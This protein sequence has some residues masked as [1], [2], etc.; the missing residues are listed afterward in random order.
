MDRLQTAIAEAR[1]ARDAILAGR[2]AAATDQEA[3]I[4]RKVAPA[5]SRTVEEAWAAL[6]RFEPEAEHLADKRVV[7]RQGGARS[8]PFDVLRTRTLQ[9]MKAQGWSRLAV[10]SPGPGCGKSTVTMNLA[11]SLARQTDIR[12]VVLDLDLRRPMLA[13]ILGLQARHEIT[14]AIRGT[15]EPGAQM[16]R[17][18]ENLAFATTRTPVHDPAE[19]LQGRRIGK[20]LERI[21][22]QF[23]PDVIVFDLPPVMVSDDA[24]A[25]L[26]NAD[27]ALMIA[28]AEQSTLGQVDACEKELAQQTN[29]LGVVLNKC[30]HPGDYHHYGY[31]YAETA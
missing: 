7:T 2:V 25:F 1:A 13:S 15:A 18:G 28:A 5:A 14:A 27:C 3:P 12:T 19:L 9:Q 31:G 6:P 26:P 30:G 4:S 16:T 11:F 8:A 23:A 10:T 24:I 21:E 20:L 29:V 22:A 17:V